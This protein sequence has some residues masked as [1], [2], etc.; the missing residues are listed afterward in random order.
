MTEQVDRAIKTEKKV[1]KLLSKLKIVEPT[2]WLSSLCA[3]IEENSKAKSK[4]QASI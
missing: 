2:G 3:A 1:R 4:N